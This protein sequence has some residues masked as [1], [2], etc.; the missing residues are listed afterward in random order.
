[1]NMQ[2]VLQMIPKVSLK[3]NS[4]TSGMKVFSWKQK[5]TMVMLDKQSSMTLVTKPTMVTTLTSIFSPVQPPTD[6][7]AT[8][9]SGD[10]HSDPE[11]NQD[12]DEDNKPMPSTEVAIVIRN[13]DTQQDETFRVL[14]DSGSNRCMGSKNAVLRAGLHLHQGRTHRYNTAAG[15]F[16]TTHYARIKAHKL[17]E[18]NSRRILLNQRVQVHDGDLGNYDFIFGRDYL[19]KYGIDL[20]FSEQVIR[21]DGMQTTMRRPG[22]YSEEQRMKEAVLHAEVPYQHTR[23][24][25]EEAFAQEI[26]ESKYDQQDLRQVANE[27]QHL[28]SKQREKLYSLLHKHSKIFEGRLGKWPGEKVSATLKPNAKPFHCGRPIRIPHV[29]METLKKEVDRLV[30]VGVLKPVDAMQ[31]G[32]W[33]APSFII[34]KKDGRVRFI[35][36][37]RQLN[38]WIER[39]PFPLPHITDLLQ[40]VGSYKYVTALDLSMGFYHFELDD[41]LSEMTT[42]MLPWGLYRYAR[43]PMGLNIS[44]DLFHGKVSTIFADMQGVRSYM[45]DLLVWSNGSYEEHLEKLDEVLNRLQ[46]KDLAVNALKSYWAVEEVDYL[47]FRLTTQGVLPQPRKVKAIQNMER[48]KSKKQL[49]GFIGLVNYYRYMWRKRSHLLAPLSSMA[50]KNSHFKWT[51][52]C[53]KAFQEIKKEVSK[54]VMLSF[55]DYT[56]SFELFTDA[57][58]YQLGAVLKQDDKTLAFF[59]KK[60]N[61]AQKRYGVGEKEMLSV[62][63]ALKEFRTMVKGY[64]INIF[65]DHKNWTHDRAFRNDRVMRW[66]LSLEEYDITFHYIKGEKNVVADALSRLFIKDLT[67][68]AEEYYMMDEAF[69]IRNWRQFYQPITI[70]EIGREQVKDTYV[71]QLKEQTP[72]RLGELFEDIGKKTGA[73]YVTTEIDSQTGKQR[74]IVPKSLRQRLMEWYHTTLVHPGIDRL[75]NTLR[76]HYVWPNMHRQL[77]DFIKN[78]DACQRGKRGGKGR[79]LLPPKDPETEPWKDIAVDLAGPWEATVNNKKM[80]FHTFTIIDVFT[81]WVE[82]I[83]IDNKEMGTICD[84]LVQE[85]LRRYPRPSRVI[86]DQGKEFDNKIFRGVCTQWYIKPEPITVR[87]PRANAIVERMHRVLGD[88]LRVQL[89]TRHDREDVVTELTSAAAYGMRATV[90]GVTQYS[91]AQLVYQKDM[92]LRTNMIADVELVRQRRQAAIAVSNARE[93]KRRIPY[94]YKPGDYVLILS[95]G[96]DPKLKLHEGPFRVVSFNKSSGTLHIQRRNYIEP[97]NIR[98]VRP[99]FGAT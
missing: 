25:G 81:G 75:H 92:I 31:A 79:G 19:N 11:A 2:L 35:T 21:W 4:L 9:N 83:P 73:D 12:D 47:G 20:I 43:L 14:L 78:C 98:L 18:L 67:S 74:I 93:N 66:R 54:E 53:D 30:K 32:P 68:S 5:K 39:R 86:F 34:P 1:M 13:K 24:N 51:P 17:L 99:Y 15:V 6:G 27:Q 60:L 10:D 48:P 63:E 59:S 38:K 42:F 55:P 50:G 91:P 85:W 89:T 3:M 22:Y 46:S 36:D 90:H 16:H 80:Q 71:K 95:G 40:D 7:A 58:D 82:I 72:D 56:K 62:V 44:P 64:P 29:H 76:Q 45:D 94:N 61:S 57:S 69:E 52:E 88:M 96:L 28:S 77:K 97:I 49:R 23:S 37:F 8:D 87:N 70:S 41:K 26:L 65:V 84:L 33:C